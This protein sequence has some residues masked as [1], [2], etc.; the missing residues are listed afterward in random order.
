MDCGDE[1]SGATT[2]VTID[3]SAF[4]FRWKDNDEY[5]ITGTMTTSVSDSQYW[6]SLPARS[7]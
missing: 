6:S 2:A 1:T 5:C 3:S 4:M 7:L